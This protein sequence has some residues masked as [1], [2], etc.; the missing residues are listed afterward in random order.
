MNDAN[1]SKP[2]W[3]ATPTYNKGTIRSWKS[4]TLNILIGDQIY[5]EPVD[6]LL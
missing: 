3:V 4:N 2:K 1:K 5:E 6:N